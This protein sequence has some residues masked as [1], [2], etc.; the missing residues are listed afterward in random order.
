MSK[1][2][3]RVFVAALVVAVGGAFSG[4]A[5]AQQPPAPK[6]SPNFAKTFKAAQEAQAAKRWPEVIAKAQEVLAASGRKPDDTYYANY[7]LFDA[8]KAQNNNPEIA[9]SLEGIIE[10]G[11]LPAPAQAPF[12]NALTALSMQT[13]SYDKAV[14]Y[15]TRLIRADQASPEIYTTVG[16][17]YFAQGKFGDATKLFSGLVGDAEKRGAKPREQDIRMLYS[18]YDKAGNK[19]GAQGALEKWVK[20]YPAATTWNALLYDVRNETQDRRQK[21]HLFRLLESTGNLKQLRD[22]NDYSD[23]ATYA[24]LPAEAQ[25]VL[26]AGIAAGVYKVDADKA[27]ADRLVASAAKTAEADKAGLAKR[28]AEAKAAANGE[29]DVALGLAYFS[30]ADY[31]RAV[32]ALQRGIGKGGLKYGADAAIT[33]GEAQLKAGD[34]A[35]ALKTF[36][37][38]KADD[39]NAQRIA[40]LWSLHAQ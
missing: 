11:F 3:V 1:S 27:R 15:G 8:Y 34:K 33:L 40:K 26:Q 38:V 10:S 4:G 39:P 30:Y 7:L 21:L 25:R 31:P 13:K 32:E 24:G 18:A 23:A 9:K 37:G 12:L 35:G 19:D 16:Q 2:F 28:E 5:M 22:F 17:A 36:A 29:L 6:V 14:E 20:F